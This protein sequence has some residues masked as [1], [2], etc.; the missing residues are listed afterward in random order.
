MS[1]D[2]ESRREFLK[3]AGKLAVY[4]PPTMLVLMY[5]GTDAIASGGHR[6]Q[7]SHEFPKVNKDR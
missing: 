7:P 2:L 4:T 6:K 5:P 1:N 3:T